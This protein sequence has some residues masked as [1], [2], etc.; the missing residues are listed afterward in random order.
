MSKY[1]KIR[2]SN[3]IGNNNCIINIKELENICFKMDNDSNIE[4]KINI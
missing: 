2:K 4:N 1:S 3:S